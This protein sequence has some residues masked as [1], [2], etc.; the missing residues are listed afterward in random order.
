[1]AERSTVDSL[2]EKTGYLSLAVYVG[3]EAMTEPFRMAK[4]IG[5]KTLQQ[6]EGLKPVL[7]HVPRLPDLRELRIAGDGETL[8][9]QLTMPEIPRPANLLEWMRREEAIRNSA[10]IGLPREATVRAYD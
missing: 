10:K 5:S 2:L 9:D 8:S 6:A 4:K 1:M 3:A 7:R